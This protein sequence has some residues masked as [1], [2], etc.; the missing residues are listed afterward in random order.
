MVNSGLVGSTAHAHT[1]PFP[2]SHHI[3]LHIDPAVKAVVG[4]FSLV[5]GKRPLFAVHGGSSRE[6]LALQNVQVRRPAGPVSLRGS[7]RGP[8]GLGDKAEGACACERARARGRGAA[9]SAV[10]VE[11]CV[12]VSVQ[13]CVLELAGDT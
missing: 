3:G 12:S 10:Q 9:E 2:G 13:V 11:A 8:G 1:R 4:I 6:N 5:T 7:H